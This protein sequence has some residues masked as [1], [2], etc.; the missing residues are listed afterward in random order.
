MSVEQL[1][2]R[3]AELECVIANT[4]STSFGGNG[5]RGSARQSGERIFKGVCYG[6]GERVHRRSECSK[7][8]SPQQSA[9][10]AVAFIELEENSNPIAFPVIVSVRSWADVVRQDMPP[11]DRVVATI[12][13]YGSSA[14]FIAQTPGPNDHHLCSE[15]QGK[16]VG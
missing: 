7:R 14:A 12:S 9:N 15:A 5:S 16:Y 11:T 4:K 10:Q 13:M 6:C 2:L 3:V 1:Q 8:P